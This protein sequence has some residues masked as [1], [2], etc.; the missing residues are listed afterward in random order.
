MKLGWGQ[1]SVACALWATLCLVIAAAPAAAVDGVIEINQT[2][3]VAGGVTGDFVSDAPGFPV[4]IRVAG[5]YRLTSNLEVSSLDA[6]AIVIDTNDVEIDLNG[7]SV[8]GPNVCTPGGCPQGIG[9]GIARLTSQSSGNRVTLRNGS[10]VGMGSNGIVLE[11]DAR[12]EDMAVSQCGGNGITVG[13]RGLLIQNRVGMNGF[14]GL[15]LGDETLY[16]RNVLSGRGANRSVTG[17][18][19]GGG[20]VCNDGLCSVRG[21]RLYYLS[22]GADSGALDS[23][24]CQ[25]GYHVASFSELAN[26]ANLVYVPVL[27]RTLADSGQGPPV[28]FGWVRT[29]GEAAT[30]GDAGTANCDA[31][32]SNMGNH[33]GTIMRLNP[34]WTTG[35][36]QI[37]PWD[38]VTEFCNQLHAVW[39]VQN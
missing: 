16:V 14:Q 38:S 9:Q 33:L 1:R 34:A 28:E 18:V 10:I 4:V 26:P 37:S 3:A 31:Y 13:E 2:V 17:G 15:F 35:A 6:P 5:S 30:A 24:S 12:I 39:C 36:V 11:D 19:S 29:G 7:F 21:E 22:E 25:A 8:R 23:G 20:N 27:G 32:D